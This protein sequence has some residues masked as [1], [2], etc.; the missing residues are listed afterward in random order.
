MTS[1]TLTQNEF[2]AQASKHPTSPL[3]KHGP[4]K[5]PCDEA[6]RCSVSPIDLPSPVVKEEYDHPLPSVES[7]TYNPEHIQFGLDPDRTPRRFD[8]RVPFP[9]HRSPPPPADDKAQ[10]Y[11]I[12]RSGG[13]MNDCAIVEFRIKSDHELMFKGPD[14]ALTPFLNALPEMAKLFSQCD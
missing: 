5:R 8:F 1:S 2:L 6:Q 4:F 12:S 3:E 10:D 14:T 7:R 9:P 13:C 11:R